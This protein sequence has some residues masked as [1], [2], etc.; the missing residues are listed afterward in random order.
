MISLKRDYLQS[1]FADDKGKTIFVVYDINRDDFLA[2]GALGKYFTKRELVSF[3][4]NIELETVV[5]YPNNEYE[6]R[7][8]FRFPIMGTKLFKGIQELENEL[9]RHSPHE[10]SLMGIPRIPP[11]VNRS[12]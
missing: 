5:V 2:N 6:E 4:S 8:D 3:L 7:P 12:E 10:S 1:F 9:M 11:G